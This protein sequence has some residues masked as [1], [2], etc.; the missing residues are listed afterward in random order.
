M[1]NKLFSFLILILFTSSTSI[2]SQWKYD[3]I[4]NLKSDVIINYTI[5]YD[6][7]LT[8]KQKKSYSYV[9][10]FVVIFNQHQLLEKRMGNSS[11]STKFTLY[12]Y[13]KEK[14]YECYRSSST[15]NAISHQFEEPLI[16]GVLQDGEKKEIAGI[17]CE[18]YIS[19]LKG[20]PVEIFTTKKLGLRYIK[21]F[22]V[23]GLLMEYRG[24]NKYLGYY[25]VKAKKINFYKLPKDTYSLD[26]YTVT[27]HEDYQKNI[28]ESRQKRKNLLEKSIGKKAPIFYARTLNNTKIS[29]KKMLE[30]D[31]VVLNFWFST[32][33]PCKA[34]IPKLNALKK[35]Y[36]DDKN[37][38][39]IAIG[40]DDEYTIEK[41]LKTHP[42]NYN[43]I[44]EGRWIAS[45]FEIT[46]YPTN[47]IIDKKGI[48]Q[49]F[50][51]GYKSNIKSI[52]T[53]KIDELLDQ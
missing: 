30:N 23:P 5:T 15:K 21:N 41:F 27:T 48:I 37:V 8:E 47:I 17:P 33:G 36:K 49:F 14:R 31:I 10:E 50:E 25:T 12:D 26:E 19:L 29:S 16:S 3:N 43:M 6:N 1:K 20:N 51:I 39:F 9:D 52:M 22:N 28:R 2:F 38:K 4:K 24:H 34:E 35:L 11:S 13:D 53:N 7:T 18:K 44:D 32:C 40:L 42:W 46:S 45:K